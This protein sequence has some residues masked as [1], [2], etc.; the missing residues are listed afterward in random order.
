M[1]N[2]FG[3]RIKEL[4]EKNNLLQRE[5]ANLLGIDTPMLSKME[6]GERKARK[7]QVFQFA[8]VFKIN[9]HELRI[10]WLADQ[11]LDILKNEDVG[12]QVIE[13]VEEKIKK[14]KHGKAI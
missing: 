1:E 2:K 11:V 14:N 6:R 3:E 7:D 10:A 5:V 12:L 4:R 9:P 13:I 8:Q